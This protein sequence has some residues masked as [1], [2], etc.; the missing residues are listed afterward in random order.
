M[1]IDNATEGAV[2]AVPHRPVAAARTVGDLMS[3]PVIT[4][5]PGAALAEASSAMVAGGVGSVVVVGSGRSDPIGILTERD[6]VRA[7]AAG[8][9]GRVATVGS[10]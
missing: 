9:D 8:A 4:V 7:A 10:G 3:H 2:G 6:L 1:S 5:G